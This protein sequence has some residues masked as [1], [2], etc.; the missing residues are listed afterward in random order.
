[1]SRAEDEL[2]IRSLAAAYT[3][4]V[5]RRDG[6]G[7]AAVYAE[8]G[9]L[10][11]PVAGEPLQGIE[12]LRK[13]FKRLVEKEREFLMQL[14]HSGVVEVDGD[15]A[16]ARW[17]FSEIKRPTGGAFE[18]VFGVYQDEMI[19]TEAGWRFA[20]R[21]VDAPLRWELPNPPEG[22]GPLPAFLPLT[23]LPKP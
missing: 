17:W 8:D 16:T 10:H 23:G 14:T 22:F 5:N 18:M 12:K 20:K 4:A 11:S 9:M 2:A 19:R 6:D 13:R 15:T 7:M 3:D 1:M 21:T